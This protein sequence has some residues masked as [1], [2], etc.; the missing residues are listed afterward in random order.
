MTIIRKLA[1]GYAILVLAVMGW[2]WWIDVTSLGSREEHLAPDLWLILVS[3]PSS[4]SSGLVFEAFSDV[5]ANPLMQ[6]VW[7]SVCGFVQ[8]AVVLLIAGF[9]DRMRS[10]AA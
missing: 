5:F 8:I 4:L 3:M 10:R 2:A 6:L 9:I 1:V 7:L